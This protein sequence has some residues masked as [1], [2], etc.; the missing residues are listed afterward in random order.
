MYDQTRRVPPYAL[1]RAGKQAGPTR[2]LGADGEL[3]VEAAAEHDPDVEVVATLAVREEGIF[4]VRRGVARH[5]RLG[6]GPA[7][8]Q[9]L[10][11]TRGEPLTVDVGLVLAVE[12]GE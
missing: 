1:D 2:S 6:T 4:S 9:D 5:Q 11:L 7:G 3:T 12:E 8:V 10:R